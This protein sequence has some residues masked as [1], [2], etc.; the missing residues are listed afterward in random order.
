[1]SD[2]FYAGIVAA[3]TDLSMDILLRSTVDNSPVTGKVAADFDT[4]YYRQGAAAPVTITESDLTNLN[5]VH[6]DGGIKEIY[7]GTYRFDL[8]DAAIATGADWVEIIIEVTGTFGHRERLPLQSVALVPD[9]VLKRD[10][11]S[12]TGEAARSLLNAARLLRNRWVATPTA[13]SVKKENDTDEAWA[14][15]LSTVAGAAPV[16][17]MDPN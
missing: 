14:G 4:R 17:A 10:F 12:V 6:S 16:T 15:S 7:I 3:S 11:A 2:K 13:I 9:Q 5:D 8:P 1:M